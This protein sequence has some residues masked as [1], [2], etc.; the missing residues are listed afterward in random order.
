MMSDRSSIARRISSLCPDRSLRYYTKTKLLTDPLYGGVLKVLNGRSEPLLDVGSGLAILSF[1]LRECGWMAPVKCID[2]DESKVVQGNA[3]IKSGEYQNITLSQGD[4][5]TDLPEHSG[6]VTIL[7]ILQ[8][9]TL[10][11]QKQLLRLAA[12]RVCP[13]GKLIIRSGLKKKSLRFFITWCGDMLAKA[14]FWMKAAPT[15][16]PTA[17]LFEKVLGDE[18]FKVE[19]SPFW[20]KTPF[21]NYLIVSTRLADPISEDQ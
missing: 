15:H 7:D 11:E 12:S 5:R 8:F 3:M 17:E 2:Y 9:F 10:D 21:N 4:A 20:G 6:D 19:V 16:Y 1:Y 13:G 14:T 18:G